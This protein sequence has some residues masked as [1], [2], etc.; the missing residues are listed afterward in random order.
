VVSAEDW[1]SGGVLSRRRISDAGALWVPE[2]RRKKHHR[3]RCGTRISRWSEVFHQS[4][5]SCLVY[6]PVGWVSRSVSRHSGRQVDNAQ[7]LAH[8]TRPA[9]EK[10]V[11]PGGM[12][13]FR[14]AP[15]VT[16]FMMSSQPQAPGSGQ[17]SSCSAG[18]LSSAPKVE[19][20]VTARYQ[21][22]ASVKPQT[23]GCML[24]QIIQPTPRWIF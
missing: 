15:L 8:P 12:F 4:R 17:V 21:G 20:D 23:S 14:A 16:T 1:E 2:V 10:K 18:R 22:K 24:P 19:Q 7:R 6:C 13:L 5:L 9:E 11:S 3:R